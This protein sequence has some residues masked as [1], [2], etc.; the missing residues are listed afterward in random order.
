MRI[1][2]LTR[3]LQGKP[4]DTLTPHRSRSRTQPA[5][6]AQYAGVGGRAPGSSSVTRFTHST[7]GLN[8]A[9]S[10]SVQLP[11]DGGR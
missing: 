9:V 10:H 3:A 4:H 11:V 2:T 8:D 1:T 7:D 6:V 5:G